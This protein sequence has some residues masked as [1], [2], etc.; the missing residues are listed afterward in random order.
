MWPNPQGT[1]DLVTFTEE[2]LNGKLNFLCSNNLKEVLNKIF[3]RASR[4]HFEKHTLY[5]VIKTSGRRL[6]TFD[7]CWVNYYFK[8]HWACLMCSLIQV[9][10]DDVAA[11]L[12]FQLENT[13]YWNLIK[14]L[15]QKNLKKGFLQH[16]SSKTFDPW[17]NN[18][19][20]VYQRFV[21][22]QKQ[23]TRGALLKECVLNILE[24]SHE[25]HHWWS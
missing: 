3:N 6:I 15:E 11:K 8:L 12:I 5:H 18:S 21:Q 7:I 25:K 20:A 19:W 14:I 16:F 13:K 10:V 22:H 2:I 23:R 24:T 17:S 9:I 1:A 4:R